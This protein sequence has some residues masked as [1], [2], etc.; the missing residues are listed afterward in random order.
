M[1]DSLPKQEAPPTFNSILVLAL[2]ALV[3]F[4]GMYFGYLNIQDYSTSKIEEAQAY[5]D[6]VEDRKPG[7]PV[8]DTD[9]K[10]YRIRYA[11]RVHA[12]NFNWTESSPTPVDY[13]Q[14]KTVRFYRSDPS[15]PILE[16]A[17]SSLTLWQVWTVFWSLVSIWLVAVAL[18]TFVAFKRSTSAQVERTRPDPKE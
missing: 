2:A 9:P 12:Q 7:A 14:S 13:G 18:K 15:E 6:H 4:A 17:M 3:P 16:N 1:T 5:V 10:R 11:Y 8:N